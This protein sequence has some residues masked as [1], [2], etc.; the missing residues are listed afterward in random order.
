MK[1][2]ISQWRI[3]LWDI[4]QLQSIFRYGFI[5]SKIHTINKEKPSVCLTNYITKQI[6]KFSDKHIL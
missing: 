2:S 1:I 3:L 4:L 5:H 6:P